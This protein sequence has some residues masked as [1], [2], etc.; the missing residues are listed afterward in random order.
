MLIEQIFEFELRG[1]R[2]PGP[3][4]LYSYNWLISWQNKNL[5][6]KSLNGLWFTAKILQEAIH[7]TSLYL[8][9]TTYKFNTKMQ[10]FKSVLNNQN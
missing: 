10:D 3:Y 8:S 4:M 9:Q 2:P 7:F 5:L 1:P 6:R